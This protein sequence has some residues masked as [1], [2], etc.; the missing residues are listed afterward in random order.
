LDSQTGA[1]FAAARIHESLLARG[2]QSRF[3]VAYPRAGLAEAFTPARGLAARLA[4][5]FQTRL[6]NW[7]IRR[8]PPMEFPVASTGFVGHDMASIIE[9][10][11]PDVV[12]LH[13]IGGNAFRLAS[14]AGVKAPV[15]WRLADTWAFCAVEHLQP[16]P[17]R[18]VSPPLAPGGLDWGSQVTWRAWRN[19]A[20]TYRR[21]HELVLACPTRWMADAARQSALLGGRRTEVIP[22][23]CDH[24]L[25]R[26]RDQRAC[27]ELFGLPP[28]APLVLVG[29]SSNSAR[30]KGSDLFAE[31]V[32]RVADERFDGERAQIVAFG[33]EQLGLSPRWADRVSHLGVI[34][35]RRLMAALYSAVDVFVAPS[36]M[37][38]LANTALEA[39]AT[40]TPVVAFRVGGM[41]EAITHLSNGFIA[42]P[43][44]TGELAAGIAWAI[45]RRRSDEVAR[46][47]RE[48]VL[49]IHSPEAETDAYVRLY[50]SVAG[51]AERRKAA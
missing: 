8:L 49:R 6:E 16:D 2:I 26:P 25:F 18:Y 47:A 20:S 48:Q 17:N 44:D 28:N 11:R 45:E 51:T 19:K 41:A 43:F 34:R 50:D 32:E 30:W 23:S 27:R 1:G 15:I 42:S 5:S 3:C 29:A 40:G 9:A 7:S 24:H 33:S 35:D 10:E 38:N 31:A 36:R 46:A 13:W 22:T 37:E 14:L 21:V 4:H 12:H 39:L